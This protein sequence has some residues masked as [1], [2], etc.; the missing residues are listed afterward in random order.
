MELIK[1]KIHDLNNKE[2]NKLVTYLKDNQII[3]IQTDTIYGFSCLA[4][5]YQAILKLNQIKNRSKGKSFILL[6]SSLNMLNKFSYINTRQKD[7]IKKYWRAKRPTSIV[8][9]SRNKLARNLEKQDSLAF[10]LPKSQIFIKIIKRLGEPIV[11]TSFNFSGHKLIDI[12]L[13]YSIFNK[14]KYKPDLI[15]NSG[16]KRAKASRLIDLTNNDIKILRK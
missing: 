1:K 2:I 11:S 13:A 10:R 4:S 12:N 5:N 6:V 9:K 16:T 3:A 8:L 14:R 7:L 15:I